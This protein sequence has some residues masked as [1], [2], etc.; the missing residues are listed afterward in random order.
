MGGAKSLA[1]CA[2]LVFLG[3]LAL[4]DDCDRY[5]SECGKCLDSAGCGWCAVGGFKFCVDKSSGFCR[6]DEWASTCEADHHKVASRV[7][8][9]KQ[10]CAALL[11]VKACKSLSLFDCIPRVSTDCVVCVLTAEDAT[12][13]AFVDTVHSTTIPPRADFSRWAR[14]GGPSSLYSNYYDY[15]SYSYS[16]SYYAY[17]APPTTQ[18]AITTPAPT[19]T[20][21]TTVP[22]TTVPPTTTPTTTTPTTAPVTTTVAPTT[23]APFTTLPTT[24]SPAPFCNTRFVGSAGTNFIQAFLQARIKIFCTLDNVKD[25]SLPPIGCRSDIA[26]IILNEFNLWMN[27]LLAKDP[28]NPEYHLADFINFNVFDLDFDVASNATKR[29][30]DGINDIATTF[31]IANFSDSIVRRFAALF[32]NNGAG[33]FGP[34]KGKVTSVTVTAGGENVGNKKKSDI[35]GG[36]LAAVIVVVSVFICIIC[37]ATGYFL[38]R[39]SQLG[40]TPFAAAQASGPQR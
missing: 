34:L 9:E 29:Q 21:P 39:R 7:G 15:Y 5:L 19:T 2:L 33:L 35:N 4:A 23:N 40:K 14:Q 8:G 25:G 17:T 30:S 38:F 13:Q 28:F 10:E 26:D 3:S 20:V 31:A 18:P 27:V 11:A 1:I 37:V 6:E 36:E 22:P 32:E 24:T 16:Y 12:C